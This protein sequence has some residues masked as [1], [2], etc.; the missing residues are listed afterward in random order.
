MDIRALHIFTRLARTL[1]FGRASRDC[2]LSP[3]ALTRTVQRIEEELG[4][5]ATYLGKSI[6]GL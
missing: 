4:D 5:A 1:H 3:S 2:G 6:F